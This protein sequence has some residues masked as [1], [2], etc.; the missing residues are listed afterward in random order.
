[1]I[2][3]IFVSLFFSM[4][5]ISSSFSAGSSDSGSSKTKTQYDMAISH[6]KAAKNFEKKDKLKKQKKDIKKHKNFYF[7]LTKNSRTK[8][9]L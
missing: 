6:V 8:L 2:K 5:L 1:M 9:I 4:L 3:T 7:N